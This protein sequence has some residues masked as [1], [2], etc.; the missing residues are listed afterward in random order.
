M[1]AIKGRTA[2]FSVLP[3]YL[4]LLLAAVLCRAAPAAEMSDRVPASSEV[5][6]WRLPPVPGELRWVNV[7]DSSAGIIH[8]E[9][10]ARAP[11]GKPWMFKRLAAHMAITEQ[12]LQASVV[13][14]G[15][16]GGAYPEAYYEERA[17]WNALD[18]AGKAPVCTT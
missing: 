3:G 15:G 4:L 13:K 14:A 8:I 2:F 5:Y 17:R 18:A 16:Y 1:P 12:A 7:K 10:L 9:V 6:S 11:K